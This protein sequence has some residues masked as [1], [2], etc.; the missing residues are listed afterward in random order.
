MKVAYKIGCTVL[1]LAALLIWLFTPAVTCVYSL[2]TT[3]EIVRLDIRIYELLQN[4]DAT[5]ASGLAANVGMRDMLK[6]IHAQQVWLLLYLFASLSMPVIAV[7]LL[8]LALFTKRRLAVSIL[9]LSGA[10][11]TAL[12]FVYMHMFAVPLLNGSVTLAQLMNNP[13]L[14]GFATILLLRSSYEQ[15]AVTLIFMALFFWCAMFKYLE[16][17]VQEQRAKKQAAA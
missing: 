4:P 6:Q 13:L 8:V 14:D 11:C 12:T 3:D 10:G 9:S 2:N 15:A 7:I 5:D 1:V 17:Y 16:P